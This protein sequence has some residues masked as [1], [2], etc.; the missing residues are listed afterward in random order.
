MEKI[1]AQKLSQFCE[2]YQKLYMGQMKV[3]KDRCVVNA[4][5]IM[6][7]DMYHVLDQEK[8]MITLLMVVKRAFDYVS[9]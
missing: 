8:M 6:I 4:L 5:A 1:V 9:N 7:I 2:S 3:L